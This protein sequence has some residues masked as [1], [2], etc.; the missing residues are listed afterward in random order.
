MYCSSINAD[1]WMMRSLL[2]DGEDISGCYEPC[3]W[4]QSLLLV[5]VIKIMDKKILKNNNKDLYSAI[6]SV[7][8]RWQS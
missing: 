1:D 2:T 6:Y 7:Q 4:L 5:I 8:E 3:T